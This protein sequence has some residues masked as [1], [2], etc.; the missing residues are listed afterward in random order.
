MR[1]RPA[2][3]TPPP[4]AS[5]PRLGPAFARLSPAGLLAAALLAAGLLAAGLLASDPAAAQVL[6]DGATAS[7]DESW[8]VGA[9]ELEYATPHPDLPPLSSL[10]PLEV[11]LKPTASGYTAPAS[12]DGDAETIRLGAA[13]GPVVRVDTPGL[14]A[15]LASVVRALHDEGL[16]G[17]D[18]RP[19]PRD[20]D[21]ERERDL[22]PP[23]RDALAL[24]V[25]VGRIA[26]V[27]TIAAGD[28]V[29]SD[30]KIDNEI[31]QRIRE[32]SPLLPSGVGDEDATDLIDRRALEDY[33]HRL[34]RFDGRRVEAALSPGEA[35]G[36]VVLDYRVHEAKPWFVYGQTSNTGTTRTNRW[37]SRVGYV[38]RQL[39]DR[40]DVLSLEYLNAGL[41]DV[42][43][44][45]ARYEAPFF[46]GDRPNW[47]I[48]RRGDPDWI[49]WLPRDD[50][51]WWGVD[52]MR[53]EAE[54]SY[55]KTQAGEAATQEN[56]ANDLVRS[57]Q[58]LVGGRMIYE[59]F[60]YR[61]FFLDVWGGLRLRD[62]RVDNRT[63]G[64][65]GDALLVI[66]RVGVRG[67]RRSQISTL[68][69]GVS[70]QSQVNSIDDSNREALGRA[71][72]DDRYSIVDF[73]LGYSTYLE[74]IL[75]PK[76]WRDPSSH[77][78]S[79]LAHEIAIGTRGQLTLDQERLI[80]QANGSIGGL[81][82][83]RGYPQSVAV[84]DSLVVGSFEYR[85]HVPRIFPVR[86][87]AL[88]LPLIGDFR[89]SPQQVYGRPDW[90]LTLRAFVDV[91]RTRRN[92]RNESNTG[93]AER[94][95]TLVGAGIGAALQIRSNLRAQIDWATALTSE[96]TV[97]NDGGSGVDA[98]DSEIHVLFSILY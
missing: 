29:R 62:L 39:S 22:R 56:L 88:N 28:R 15:V 45:I 61:S 86:R 40:D 58:F 3:P 1:R 59:A 73:D 80:P 8:R 18:V 23:E 37:Q 7:R 52:R 36:E 2:S 96:K 30:W 25:R 97:P 53:W 47:M 11:E 91:G 34:N 76:A 72:T 60:Q 71:A 17:V 83:V 24:V 46:G 55:S 90:D 84:G 82:S 81:Y 9:L 44:V 77:L 5:A 63:N 89:L 13:D 78:S 14:V 41:D 54:F 16:Y 94:H 31:H 48:E 87:E 66:P 20:V 43:A 19:S 12:D 49:E 57:E 21:L 26:R 33:L 85:F 35:P 79:T 32:D 27:R 51:P 92:R 68:G 70:L 4:G 98:G 74:P 69:F 50:I 65:E 93:V 38:H 10:L 42:N 95:Q 6:A 67:E 75:N 64:G